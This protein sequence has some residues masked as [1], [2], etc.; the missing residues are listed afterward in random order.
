MLS[1]L[2]NHSVFRDARN[3][4]IIFLSSFLLFG[5]WAL[6]W[7]EEPFNFYIIA[8]TAILVQFIAIKYFR[9]PLDSLKSA[10]ITSFGLTLLFKTDEP[11]YLVIAAALAIGSKFLIRFRGKHLFNP[12]TF[13]IIIS[14]ILFHNGWISPGKWGSSVLLLLMIGAAGLMVLFKAGRI[15]TGLSFLVTLFILD[16]SR[17]VIYQGWEWDVLFHKYFNGSL[18]LFSFFMI[19][20]PATTPNHRKARIIWA[21]GVALLTFY[22][23]SYVQL[24]TAPI[25]A[26]FIVSPLTV[27]LDL[28]LKAKKF[29]WMP[30]NPIKASNSV[31]VLSML[32]I[33][34]TIS[35]PV[36]AFC[37]FYVAKADV[38]L[39]NKS[40]QVILVRN[41]D[42][43]IITMN[44]DF[45]GPVRDFAMVVPVPVVLKKT[46]IRIVDA[47]LFTTLDAYSGPRLVEY[48]DE[49]PCYPAVMCDMAMPST[50]RE[51]SLSLKESA[52]SGS[53]RRNK[54]TIEAQYTVGEYDILI[55]SAK[56]S[57]GLRNWLIE[58]DYKIPSDANGVLE[59]YIKSGMKFFV[60]KVNLDE[61]KKLGFNSLRPI[62]ISFDSPKFMLPI[63]L[64]MA[65]ANGDQDMIVYAFSKT[66]RVECTN[67]ITKK[68]PTDRKV[69]L[70]IEGKFG[71]FYKALF[72]R[73]WARHKDAVYVEYAWNVTPS[74]RGMK[75]DP[76][77]G[78]PP[79]TADLAQAGVDWN[80]GMG[81]E[82]VFFTRLHVRY[83][84]DYFPQDLQFQETPNKENFQGRYILT[85]PAQGDLSCIEGQRYLYE[86]TR[87]RQ[88]EVQNIAAL[89][90]WSTGPYNTYM[91]EYVNRIKNDQI[92]QDLMVPLIPSNNDDSGNGNSDTPV[93]NKLFTFGI[94]LTLTAI[95]SLKPRRKKAIV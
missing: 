62:Q 58:N 25:W 38:K 26:L 47:S 44:S 78:P 89:T 87:R 71:K 94:I 23:Q 5:M 7:T 27:I 80:N 35:Q 63:R 13:G 59:P 40:S 52:V 51:E 77:V 45:D 39:F 92:K 53:A 61:Q 64:G 42:K 30:A 56:E 76:C 91:N 93:A 15:D 55:L 28:M 82:Q 73:T 84:R 85:H 36:S 6:D 68:I 79:L 83:G 20:D 46:D 18:L 22:L 4:Q 95:F 19:T 8:P 74:F 90:G 21:A 17:L 48:Y 34:L 69:P 50:G 9:L 88:T 11:I 24:H 49:N 16:M 86:L 75:C 57:Y 2:Q 33:F 72:D 66:G 3:W 54:V 29:E 41:G 43:S 14:I 31:V 81:G 60:V 70:D 1:Y 65:N 37:G 67:Y 12:A 10:L 32:M